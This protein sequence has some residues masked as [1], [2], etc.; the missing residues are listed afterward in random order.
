MV[1][2]LRQDHP[3]INAT[4]GHPGMSGPPVRPEMPGAGRP[5]PFGPIGHPGMVEPLRQDH[6]WINATAGHPG[7]SGPAF[8]HRGSMAMAAPRFA[9]P[10]GG[11][12]TN[13]R[14]GP[15]GGFRPG[16]PAQAMRAAEPAP[17]GNTAAGKRR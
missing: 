4:A 1:E 7:M 13:Q 6:P 10:Q 8:Q 12:F 3:W 16:A 11:G 5:P 9:P 2:S 17:H 14:P 15:Q